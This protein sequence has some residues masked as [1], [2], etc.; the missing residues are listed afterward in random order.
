[1]KFSFR[2]A[3]Q[4]SGDEA[5]QADAITAPPPVDEKKPNSNL[6]D[7]DDDLVDGADGADLAPASTT[8]TQDIEYPSGVRLALILS[9]IFVSMFLV[10][11]DRMIIATAIPK[12]TDEFNSVTDIGWYG[13][14][15]LLT[16]CAFQLMF[17][18][19]YTFYRYVPL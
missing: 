9:S 8:A 13:S 11:L 17:G 12:I 15:Y 6:L 1:M 19:L 18:K 10:A 14:A 5:T 4:P 16:T 7:P 2:K 3:K